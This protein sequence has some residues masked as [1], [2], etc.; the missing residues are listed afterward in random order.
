M[1]DIEDGLLHFVPEGE[2]ESAVLD[3][4]GEAPVGAPGGA[5]VQTG[6]ALE[7]GLVDE[8]DVLLHVLQVALL[9]E[10]VETEGSVEAAAEVDGGPQQ[11]VLGQ[12]QAGGVV[13][14]GGGL[15]VVLSNFTSSTRSSSAM[16]VRNRSFVF[17]FS[18][19]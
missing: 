3:E 2:V 16:I 8:D 5:E 12:L 19:E 18:S 4:E 15:L 9:E 17:S 10:V 14:V 1:D 13:C 11:S 7:G 6:E